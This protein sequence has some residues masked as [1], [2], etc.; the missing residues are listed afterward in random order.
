MVIVTLI[1]VLA[2]NVM[3]AALVWFGL[4]YASRLI[5]S[6]KENMPYGGQEFLPLEQ[7]MTGEDNV[8]E[9]IED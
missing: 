9:D 6:V 4:R 2:G 1:A 7:G 5:Y 8:D 3:G